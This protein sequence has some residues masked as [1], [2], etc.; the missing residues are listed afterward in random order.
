[1]SVA[2]GD[3][4]Y[5]LALDEVQAGLAAPQT[6]PSARVLDAMQRDFGSSYTR[7]AR[8]QSQATRER[9][10]ALPYPTAMQSRFEAMAAASVDKQCEIEAGDTMP[11]EIYRQQYLAPE[12]LGR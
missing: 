12:R 11:F 10:L 6:L 5:L 3:P 4:R 9:L 7:F 1:V 2:L 8:A